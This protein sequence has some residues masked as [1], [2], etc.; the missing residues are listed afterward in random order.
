MSRGPQLGSPGSLGL[1]SARGGSAPAL[2]WLLA[3]LSLRS[4]RARPAGS[5]GRSGGG[6][7]PGPVAVGA[8]GLGVVVVAAARLSFGFNFGGRT[9][10]RHPIRGMGGRG[11]LARAG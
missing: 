2:S 11:P 5:G 3:E 7:L 6:G 10:P 4:L 1:L 9:L 8:D